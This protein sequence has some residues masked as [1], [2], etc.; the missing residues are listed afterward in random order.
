PALFLLAAP[1]LAQ[2]PNAG[3]TAPNAPPPPA[4]T[5]AAPAPDSAPAL[6]SAQSSVETSSVD[7][8]IGS[9]SG[10]LNRPHIQGY[11]VTYGGEATL[12]ADQVDGD[13]RAGHKD[14][15]LSGHI[16]LHE[17]DTTLR[18]GEITFNGD[19]QDG[20]ATDALINQKIFTVQSAF[21][22]ANP[23]LLTATNADVMT[24]PPGEKADFHIHAQMVTLDPVRRRGVLRNA[25]LYLFGTRL[26]TVPRVTFRL[27]AG[28]GDTA[29]RTGMLPTV[30]VSARYGTYLAFGN[31]LHVARQTVQY[32][33][34]L[35]TRQSVE[36]TL[37]SRQTLYAPPAPAAPP[38]APHLGPVMLLERLRA[39]ATA[40]LPV[41][42]DGDPL[43]FHDFLPEPNPIRLFNVPSRG[44]L[45]LA[46]EL[47]THVAAQGRLRD[48]LYVS[49]LPEVTLRAQIPLT[50][51]PAPPAYGDAAAFRA[52]LRHLVFYAEAQETVGEYREQPTN[53][54][55]R[56][57]RSQ[58]GFSAYPLLVAPNT[59]FQPR[60]LIS[61]SG[62]NGSKN[63]YRYDQL[64]VA[65][66]HY[67]SDLTAVGVQFLASNTGGDSPFN[68]DVL[69]TSREMDLRLQ[70]G[71]GR[72]ITAGRIRYD[73]S[74][75]GVIDYQIA[76][77][78]ALNGFIPVFSYNFRTRTVGLGLEIKGVTF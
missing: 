37:T 12:D 59:V 75:H 57:V 49:R 47:S 33:L 29:R 39:F 48:D 51:L 36:A 15:T 3:D 38:A 44:G 72:L 31:D 14:Y 70:I 27:G 9:L 16:R 40:P 7:T 60:V 32:R 67:F 4:I 61:T 41:L 77:A 35:P 69:D 22:E 78:P 19:T 56:R 8:R 76:V 71:R 58:L 30:G 10:P 53:V 5:P 65:L 68:F 64:D 21:L 13:L 74:H 62:Y 11:H 43:R 63:A 66:N 20:S 45:E 54:N 28:G 73:L 55:A 46:E 17:A 18:A 24:V 2:M 26:L 6:D 42:P 23:K 52:A 1:A 50:R 34:L 25:T